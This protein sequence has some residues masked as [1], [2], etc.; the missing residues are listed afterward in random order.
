M[1]VLVVAAH[2]D[3]EVLG[4][5]GT[6]PILSRSED[7]HILI[8]GEGITSRA[9]TRESAESS[10]VSALQAQA[11]SVADRLGATVQFESLPDNRFDE[12]ALLDVVKRVAAVIERVRPQIVYTHH[13]GDL[14]IDHRTTFH[15]VLT[16]TRPGAGVT[17]LY[18]FEIPS[19][20]EW[21]F[22]RIEPI[23]RPNV[24]VDI[25]ETI[26]VKLEAMAT[27]V[28]EMRPYPHPRSVRAMKA[29]SERWGSVAGLDHAEAFELV[30]SIRA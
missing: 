20:T 29:I 27:Y 19:A 3:D 7:I 22:Q 17:D 25:T 26:E 1:T 10:E 11:R 24:F 6:I 16:A 21:A 18:C 2:P 5:G 9:A 28:D 8:M 15:A 12:L 4:A 23:F 13:P 14:N 30:R